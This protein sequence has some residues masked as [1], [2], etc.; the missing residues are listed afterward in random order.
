[1]AD[2]FKGII[3]EWNASPQGRV[4]IKISGKTYGAFGE[5]ADNLKHKLVDGLKYIEGTYYDKEKDGITYHNILT[6]NLEKEP[7]V[8]EE[9][10]GV[11]KQTFV[12]PFDREEHTL[13]MAAQKNALLQLEIESRLHPDEFDTVESI[14]QRQEV[15]YN[16]FL[17]KLKGE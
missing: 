11:S 10:I 5:L 4:A 1:M 3:D 8:T 9:K 15:L 17:S 7:E 12:N 16:E 6:V 2:E 14:G 13:K